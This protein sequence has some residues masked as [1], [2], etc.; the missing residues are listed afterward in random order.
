MFSTPLHVKMMERQSINDNSSNN[1]YD[2]KTRTL[3][4]GMVEAEE[5][6][7]ASRKK[8]A[9]PDYTLKDTTVAFPISTPT[10]MN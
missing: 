3:I 9:A 5:K 7:I 6:A 1:D 4:Q 8:Q 2:K 10:N